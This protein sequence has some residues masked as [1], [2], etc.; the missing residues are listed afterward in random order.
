MSNGRRVATV[1]VLQE[2]I[3]YTRK[4]IPRFSSP[5]PAK[6]KNQTDVEEKITHR[7]V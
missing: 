2:N 3:A 1:D 7:S 4:V 6:E 5:P